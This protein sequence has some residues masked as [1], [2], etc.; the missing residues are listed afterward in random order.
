MLAAALV[1]FLFGFIGSVPVAGPIA[2]LVFE[3]SL[4][5]R[6]A[7]A[8]GIALGGA[9][10]EGLYAGAAFLGL[11]LTVHRYPSV[12]VASRMLGAVVLLV[13]ALALYRGGRTRG[14]G[15]AG[16]G[17]GLGFARGASLGFGVTAFNPTLLATWSVVAALVF[18]RLPIAL[19]PG[20][21]IA[22]PLGA[23]L[24][25]AAWLML[26]VRLVKRG[27]ERMSERAL[28]RVRVAMVFFVL[29][30]AAWF[31]VSAVRDSV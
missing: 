25:I 30:I 31:A 24:G 23:C 14:D 18:A 26:F 22:F 27:G 2:V 7:D 6:Y 11:G 29:A 9:L 1:G 17:P 13:V 28:D 21:A 10:A 8:D 20:T 16:A 12:L 3:R 4:A 5:G 15:T 19:T